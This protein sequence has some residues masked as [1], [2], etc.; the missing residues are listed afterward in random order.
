MA[1]P[2]STMR[3]K[4]VPLIGCPS[5]IISQIVCHLDKPSLRKLV[6][7]SRQLNTITTPYLY[8]DIEIL[9]HSQSWSLPASTKFRNLAVLLLKRPHLARYVRHSTMR[10]NSSIDS[11]NGQLGIAHVPQSLWTAIASATHSK[12]EERQWLEDVSFTKSINEDAMMALLL[13]A[14]PN[15][16]TLDL[17][18]GEYVMYFSRMMQRASRKEKPFDRTPALKQLSDIMYAQNG[19][20]CTY[21][22]EELEDTDRDND[23]EGGRQKF[24]EHSVMPL[25]RPAVSRIFGLK[26]S[27]QDGFTTQEPWVLPLACGFSSQLSHL[28]LREC[29]LNSQAVVDLL[30]VPN[31]L[32]NFIYEV[33]PETPDSSILNVNIYRAMEY[34]MSSLENIWLDCVPWN[35]ELVRFTQFDDAKPMPSLANFKNLRVMR[36]ASPFLFGSLRRLYRERTG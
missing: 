22:N 5:E 31:A 11:R 35:E 30:R 36:I 23:E 12:E 28:E 24:S 33:T 3:T 32:K 29:L 18:L 26:S 9:G 21:Y 17:T 19:R 27:F 16:T 1:V 25:S 34:Q 8:D 20:V 4:Q 2:R 15:L 7:S 14:L 10:K 6:L 13:P